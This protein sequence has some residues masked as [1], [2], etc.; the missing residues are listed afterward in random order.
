MLAVRGKEEEEDYV[1]SGKGT[2]FVTLLHNTV[3]PIKCGRRILEREEEGDRR[4][5]MDN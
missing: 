2:P 1:A 4:R 3:N 5:W